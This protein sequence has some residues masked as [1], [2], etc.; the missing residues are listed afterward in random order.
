MRLTAFCSEESEILYRMQCVNRMIG[1][2][3]EACTGISQ[4]R[5]EL[6][7]LLFQADEISQTDLQKKVNIDSAAVT[8]HLKQLETK[9]MVSRR[10]KPEDNRVTLVSLTDEGRVRIDSSKKEKDRFIKEMLENVS[11]EERKLLTDV[12]RRIQQNIAKIQT[13]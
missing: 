4:S 7:S 3:F 12:L 10:R 1:V 11:E 8:R 5:L 9:D 6:L 13:T 2:K